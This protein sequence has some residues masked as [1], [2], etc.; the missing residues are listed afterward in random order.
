MSNEHTKLQ[1][2][3]WIEDRIKKSKNPDRR[4]ELKKLRDQKRKKVSKN[5]GL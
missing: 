1:I 4:E 2:R 5:Y 3:N